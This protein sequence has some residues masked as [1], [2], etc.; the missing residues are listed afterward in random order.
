MGRSQ[1]HGFTLLEIMATV[2]IIAILTVVVVPQ[3][4]GQARKSKASA[5]VGYVFGELG[6]REDQY[7]LEKGS[8]LGAT[9]CPATLPGP[10]G[11]T[12]ASLQATGGCYAPTTSA[13]DQ[14]RVRIGEAKISC[15]YTITVG[16]GTGTSAPTGF[17]WASPSTA[18]YYVLATCDTDGNATT[19]SQYFLASTDTT[20]Q[21]TNE[22]Q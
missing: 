2:A 15:Q 12:I 14:L 22:G 6:V 8:Y 18:W 5:E 21:K 19:N 3:F 13:W 20:I 9:A 16:S 10:T 1:E 7:K 11:V 17:T 4:F